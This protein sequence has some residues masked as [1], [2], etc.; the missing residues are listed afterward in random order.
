MAT[1]DRLRF[2]GFIIHI[3]DFGLLA[4]AVRWEDKPFA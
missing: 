3:H 1:T 2:I 4:A